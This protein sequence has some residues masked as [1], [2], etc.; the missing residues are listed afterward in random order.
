MTFSFD[1][2]NNGLYSYDNNSIWDSILIL[3]LFQWLCMVR[4]LYISTT[5]CHCMLCWISKK[6]ILPP[7][8]F[9]GRWDVEKCTARSEKC[10]SSSEKITSRSEKVTNFF[11]SRSTYIFLGDIYRLAFSKKVGRRKNRREKWKES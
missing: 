4:F 1:C 9:F 3:K 7:P 6:E 8:H 11:T 2:I 5:Y 10:T